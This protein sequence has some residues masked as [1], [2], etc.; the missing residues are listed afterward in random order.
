MIV[1]NLFCINDL[2]E[3]VFIGACPNLLDLL[4]VNKSLGLKSRVISSANQIEKLPKEIKPIILKN[5]STNE[6]K[7][8]L[9]KEFDV[10]K[11]IFL[12]ISS[13][14]IFKKDIIRLLNGNLLNYFPSRLP[15]DTGRGGFSWHILR[16]DRILNNVIH[17]IDETVNRGSIIFE[18]KKIF[19]SHCKVP[20]D[21]ENFKWSEMTNFYFQFISKL[22][23]GN[24][25]NLKM[26]SDSIGRHNPSLN[27]LLNG[28]IDWNL[29]SYSLYNFINAFDE[30]FVG[31]STFV[32]RGRFGKLFLK[33][34]HLHGGDTSNHPFMSGLISRHDKKWLVVS[35]TGKH[36]L[37]VEKIMNLAGENIID[38]LKEGDRFFTPLK[39]IEKSKFDHIIYNPNK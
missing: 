6:V 31:A 22:K 27:T 25:F 15:Y 9:K 24:N 19:P 23:K 26:Q 28:Y 14:F 34:I 39:Y 2:K 7:K 35:T 17:I 33:K 29:D 37:L 13:M 8:F 1:N 21:Y 11:T 20:I 32:N 38:K 12:S 16:E 3:I 5:F 30:P 4:N 36:M 18:E 10:N